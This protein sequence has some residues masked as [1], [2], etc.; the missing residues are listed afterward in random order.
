MAWLS[1]IC[2]ICKGQH[3]IQVDQ[4]RFRLLK[5]GCKLHP[6]ICKPCFDRK[7]HEIICCIFCSRTGNVFSDK[8][9]PF[10]QFK[11]KNQEV[12]RDWIL[13]WRK[14]RMD[15]RHVTSF[16]CKNILRNWNHCY[17]LQSIVTHTFVWPFHDP[18]LKENF[19]KT[20]LEAQI[21]QKC[22]K[23]SI[24]YARISVNSHFLRRL[25][26]VTF[27]RFVIRNVYVSRSCTQRLMEL[28]CARILAN[29]KSLFEISLKL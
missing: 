19:F 3:T 23:I 15:N 28:I 8:F 29:F 14:I 6:F 26:S 1:T 18:K 25:K 27:V 16:F 5:C 10:S 12:V 22:S 17:L 2:P 7:K 24:S 4:K 11:W 9:D 20:W 21:R 13:R